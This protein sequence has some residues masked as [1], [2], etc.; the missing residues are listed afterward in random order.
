MNTDD[1]KAPTE[2]GEPLSPEEQREN[3]R[4]FTERMVAAAARYFEATGGVPVA[5]VCQHPDGSLQLIASATVDPPLLRNALLAVAQGI[6]D[7]PATPDD[8]SRASV[9]L[10]LPLVR[11]MQA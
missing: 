1:K 9:P 11:S 4:L 2:E 7:A 5:I 3:G 10:N 6:R 8:L